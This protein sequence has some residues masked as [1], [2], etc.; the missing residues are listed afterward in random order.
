MDRVSGPDHG[1]SWVIVFAC[2]FASFILAGIFRTSGVL[3]VAFID[4]FGVTREE[5]SW[6]MVVCI[7]VLNLTGPFSGIL[8]QKFGA[9]PIIFTGALVATIGI[10]ACYLTTSLKVITILFGGVFGIGYGFMNTLM[11]GI[12]NA[13]F[14]NLRATANGIAN[15]GSCIGSIV[16]PVVFEFFISNYGLSGCFLLT[17]GLVLHIAIA[18]SL[19]RAPPWLVK[20]CF[21]S[22]NYASNDRVQRT[23]IV[24]SNINMRDASAPNCQRSLLENGQHSERNGMDPG[25]VSHDV[26]FKDN[27]PRDAFE[28]DGAIINPNTNINSNFFKD[29][30]SGSKSV[31]QSE[32]KSCSESQQM[33]Q[34]PES[35]YV[36]QTEETDHEDKEDL[37]CLRNCHKCTTPDIVQSFVTVLTCPMFYIT[38]ITNVSFYFLYHMYVVIIVDYALDSGVPELQAKYILFGFSMADLVGRLSFGWVTDRRL[39]SRPH[40]VLGCM[41]AIG[42]VF[43]MFP[44]AKDCWSLVAVS[45]CY[46]ILLGCTMV[47]FPI[48]L[49]DFCGIELHAVSYGCMCFMNGLAS[50]GR[51]FLIGYFRDSLGSYS[52]MFYVLGILSGVSS[53]LWLLEKP[54]KKKSTLL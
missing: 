32:K 30:D 47:V 45:C 51:P 26:G 40:F 36:Y 24:V 15:S 3:F 53:S 8:G 23:E 41:A 25:E 38:A 33:L 2:C 44:F 46:G 52:S 18:A 12:L 22:S 11:P 6:P 43:A 5:A 13:Y 10:S 42:L 14:L 49:V 17:G 27:S 19:M 20:S 21:L 37:F 29:R 1:W 7:A 4:T 48:L 34:R 28:D 35:P 9:R 50:F 16:L 39:V 54:F 31:N